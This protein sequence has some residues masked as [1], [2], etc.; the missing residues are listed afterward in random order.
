V[1]VCGV[2]DIVQP[3]KLFGSRGAAGAFCAKLAAC[4]RQSRS[5]SIQ[6]RAV[7]RCLIRIN[8]D[9]NGKVREKGIARMSTLRLRSYYY[10]RHLRGKN[11]SDGENAL[12]SLWKFPALHW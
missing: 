11:D 1:L 3:A 2:P 5:A 9:I 4:I 12:L 6:R 8:P 7:E 10:F